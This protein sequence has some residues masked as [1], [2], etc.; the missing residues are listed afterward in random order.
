MMISILLLHLDMTLSKLYLLIL[1]FNLQY[2][3]PEDYFELK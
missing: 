3:N 1:R 2:I